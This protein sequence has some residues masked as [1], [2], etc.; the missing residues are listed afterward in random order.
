MAGKTKPEALTAE[1]NQKDSAGT[2][3]SADV[4]TGDGAAT[5]SGDATGDGA[6]GDGTETGADGAD[7]DSAE[8][9]DQ[10]AAVESWV[11]VQVVRSPAGKRIRGGIEFT[12][13]PTPLDFLTLTQE[14]REK[15]M[16]DPYLRVKPYTPAEE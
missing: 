8:T 4:T 12:T 16:L 2:V 10:E 6:S 1:D 9:V 5:G 3:T 13:T 7:G 15:I 14:Q 11:T